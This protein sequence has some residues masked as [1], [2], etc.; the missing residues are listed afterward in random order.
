MYNQFSEKENKSRRIFPMKLRKVLTGALA[1]AVA[2]ASMSVAAS[3]TLYV[4][5]SGIAAGTSIGTGMW[6]VQVFNVGNEAENKP[7]TDY[8]IDVESIT[9]IEFKVTP[10]DYDEATFDSSLDGG[11][12]GGIVMSCN[13]GDLGDD[14]S[15]NWNSLQFW[16]IGEQTATDQPGI[17]EEEGNGVWSIAWDVPEEYRFVTGAG[18]CQIAFQEWGNSFVDLEV[19]SLACYD[20]SGNVV[21]SFDGL[22]NVTSGASNDTAADDTA[23][24]DTA[25]DDTA[26]DDTTADTTADTTTDTTT[27]T[28]GDKT[29]PDTGVEGVAAVAGLAI[30]ATGAVIVSKKRK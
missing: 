16:G 18:C 7:A 28:T 4:P 30:V 12:G 8:G 2:V 5:D 20:A 10:H 21:I 22:G 25:A 14:Q 23:A 11:Y 17:L 27:T 29:T 1:S 13:G 3:A 9:K 6:L 19:L 24:D 15:R 26:A